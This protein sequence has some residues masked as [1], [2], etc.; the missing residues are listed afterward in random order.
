MFYNSQQSSFHSPLLSSPRT[1]ERFVGEIEIG[2]RDHSF[3]NR[4]DARGEIVLFFN[5]MARIE[6]EQWRARQDRTITTPSGAST[7]NP[8]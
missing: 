2:F 5:Q 1:G 4:V 3:E 7:M 8:G 6:R